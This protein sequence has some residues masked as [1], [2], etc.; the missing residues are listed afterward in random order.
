MKTPR[1]ISGWAGGKGAAFPPPFNKVPLKSS[2]TIQD[3]LMGSLDVYSEVRDIGKELLRSNGH[4]ELTSGFIRLRAYLRQAKAFYNAAELMND[5][6][7][8]LNYY[9]S[10][11]NFAKAYIFCD[12][13]PPTSD[14]TTGCL[15]SI[16]RTICGVIRS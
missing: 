11:M 7:S 16:G 9:Y 1:M 3:E 5:R 13:Q 10:F 2:G 12:I 4:T 6:A 8:A 14:F 15:Q